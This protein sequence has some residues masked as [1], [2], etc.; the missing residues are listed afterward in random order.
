M[1]VDDLTER[2]CHNSKQLFDVFNDG[3]GMGISRVI[4][5]IH[6]HVFIILDTYVNIHTH[7]CKCTCVLYTCMHTYLCTYVLYMHIYM[8]H[9]YLRII[10]VFMCDV[11]ANRKYGSTIYNE[12]SSRSHTVFRILLSRKKEDHVCKMSILV[13]PQLLHLLFLLVHTL[14]KR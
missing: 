5:N 14:F 2:S 9:V 8:H 1:F 4:N 6:M 11:T 13:S 12:H 3:E 7:I 10:I